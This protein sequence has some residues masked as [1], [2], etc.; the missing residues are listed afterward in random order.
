MIYE[1][2][3]KTQNIKFYIKNNKKTV[4][5]IKDINKNAFKSSKCSITTSVMNLHDSI[6]KDSDFWFY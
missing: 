3:L 5:R 2:S 6:N 4:Y 1:N